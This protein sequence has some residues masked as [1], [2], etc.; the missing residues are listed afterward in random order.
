MGKVKDRY[1]NTDLKPCYGAYENQGDCPRC[2]LEE[3]CIQETIALD[4]YYDSQAS[5][6]EEMQEVLQEG[7]SDGW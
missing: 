2:W 7:G 3:P 1:L 6:Y 4:G 5:W